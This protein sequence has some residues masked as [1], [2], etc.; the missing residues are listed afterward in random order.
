M[1]A[2]L[3]LAGVIAQATPPTSP[4]LTAAKASDWPALSR[5]LGLPADFA[6]TTVTALSLVPDTFSRLA[7]ALVSPEFVEV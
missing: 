7:I 6:A 2:R 4:A 1:V 3:N 5:A